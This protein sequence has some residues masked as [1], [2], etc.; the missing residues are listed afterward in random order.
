MLNQLITN[1]LIAGSIYTLIAIG[2]TLIYK[3]VKFFHLAHGVVYSVGAYLAY[4]F[5]IQAGINPVVSFILAIGI[6]AAFGIGI[7]KLVYAPLWHRKASKLIFLLASFGVFVLIQNLL[8]MIYGAQ[9]L[10][11]R[12]GPIVEGHHV[13]GAVITNIQI[14]IIVVTL[15]LFLAVWWFLQNTRIGKAM[16][17]VSD[18]PIAA[19]VVGIDSEKMIMAAFGIGS[20]LAAVGG[21]LIAYETNIEP[22]MGFNAILKGMIASIVGGIGS[23]PGV[24]AG[25]VALGGIPELLREFTEFR[26]LIYGAALIVMMLV[27]TQ[28]LLPSGRRGVDIRAEERAQDRWLKPEVH[29]DQDAAPAGAAD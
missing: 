11:I 25:E 27:R 3:T 8:Q 16:R 17:A 19:G 2:F 18:D 13:L 10:T 15:L 12:T 20:A 21:I 26:L 24:V 29:G 4:S 7:D 14:V 9:I 28:G 6:T 22:T 23:R 5:S 1:G